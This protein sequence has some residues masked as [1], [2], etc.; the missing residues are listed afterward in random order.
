[1]EQREKS[2]QKAKTQIEHRMGRESVTHITRTPLT[3]SSRYIRQPPMS[4][5]QRL[6]SYGASS[7]QKNETMNKASKLVTQLLELL[8]TPS[9]KQKEKESSRYRK[10]EEDRDEKTSDDKLVLKLEPSYEGS[11]SLFTPTKPKSLMHKDETSP[12]DRLLQVTHG[13]EILSFEDIQQSENPQAMDIFLD[14]LISETIGNSQHHVISIK[15][16]TISMDTMF[17]R[18]Q[19]DGKRLD[20]RSRRLISRKKR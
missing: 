15:N 1:M 5:I 20:L 18:L 13:K 3:Q 2:Q 11:K 4:R 8:S 10:L 17:Q 9:S 7:R 6:K 14:W 16:R 12:L 19:Y